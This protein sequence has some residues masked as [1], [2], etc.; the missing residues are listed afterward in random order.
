M[1][2]VKPE[3][4]NLGR[5]ILSNPAM[6]NFALAGGTALALQLN[7]RQSVDLDF[8]TSSSFDVDEI[9][10]A[11][12]RVFDFQVD[13]FEKN[14]IK[15]YA[16]GIKIDFL[17]HQYNNLQPFNE[18]LGL[19]QYSIQ[20]IGAMKLNA[21][22]H[23]GTRVKDFID[24]YFI[25]KQYTMLDLINW[26]KI[27]YQQENYLHILTSLVYFNDVLIED[28]PIVIGEKSLTWDKVKKRI[29]SE[30]NKFIKKFLND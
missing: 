7:H 22:A 15:G 2:C 30:N 21:I 26:Y 13:Y 25:L 3:L 23:N 16:N 4:I 5:L 27:K 9:I 29:V 10:V 18:S 17:S 6:R 11:L 14:T 12:K 19:R 28:W 8:F 24:V 1:N 20:D